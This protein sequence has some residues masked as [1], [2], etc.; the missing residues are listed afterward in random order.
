MTLQDRQ[1]NLIAIVEDLVPGPICPPKPPKPSPLPVR[2]PEGVRRPFKRRKIYGP[3]IAPKHPEDAF[4]H[5]WLR[6]CPGCGFLGT[7][8][9]DFLSKKAR[10]KVV[11]V[12]VTPAPNRQVKQKTRKEYAPTHCGGLACPHCGLTMYP[13]RWDPINRTHDTEEIDYWCW[14]EG[15][16][17]WRIERYLSQWFRLEEH[18]WEEAV[19]N[20]FITE[21]K[22]GDPPPK[23]LVA[24]LKARNRLLA[25]L[26]KIHDPQ[27]PLPVT[28]E[29]KL[30]D[31]VALMAEWPI[32]T[33]LSLAKP[34]H[35]RGE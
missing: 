9:V 33:D 31:R 7:V 24:A 2:P 4:I 10:I 16:V 35:A 28:V 32:L 30:M 19:N 3:A 25:N 14:E 11:S 1:A 8:R 5:P 23:E 21:L 34:H 27:A 13:A 29:E 6:T 18:A 22:P 20:G 17:L 26:R 15:D 12:E